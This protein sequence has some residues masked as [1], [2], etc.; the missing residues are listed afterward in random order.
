MYHRNGVAKSYLQYTISWKN[1]YPLKFCCA[2]ATQKSAHWQCHVCQRAGC[3]HTYPLD[4]GVGLHGWVFFCEWALFRKWVPFMGGVGTLSYLDL[5]FSPSS[6][7][8]VTHGCII[9]TIR[10]YIN[11][12]ELPGLDPPIQQVMQI[13]QSALSHEQELEN[14]LA[15]MQE[16]LNAARQLA[17]ESMIVSTNLSS[18]DPRTLPTTSLLLVLLK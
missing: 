10:L 14:K 9:A 11:D 7:P 3:F 1:S 6:S 2:V 8:A 4:K 16:V 17:S 12:V 15:S 13:V 5:L 18:H